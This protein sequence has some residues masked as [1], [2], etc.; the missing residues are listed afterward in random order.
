MHI[1]VSCLH[2]MAISSK[3]LKLVSAE[4]SPA[5]Q[6]ICLDLCSFPRSLSSHIGMVNLCFSECLVKLLRNNPSDV[7]ETSDVVVR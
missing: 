2:K 1:L 7:L 4:D 3:V 6:N 5:I